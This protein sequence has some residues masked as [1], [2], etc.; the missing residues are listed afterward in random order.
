[1]EEAQLNERI[2]HSAEAVGLKDHS[3]AA[4]WS[5]CMI[6]VGCGSGYRTCVVPTPLSGRDRIGLWKGRT[7]SARAGDAEWS[8]VKV[9]L[10]NNGLGVAVQYKGDK[11]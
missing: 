5:G 4:Q 2:A 7:S 8:E 11:G 3:V 6:A 1:M 9:F 10:K